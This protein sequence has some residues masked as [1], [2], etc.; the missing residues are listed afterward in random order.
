MFASF[1]QKEVS[2]H[3]RQFLE[4]VSATVPPFFLFSTSLYYSPT[5]LSDSK[6]S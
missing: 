4:L 3:H 5:S 1:Q 6:A 2:A